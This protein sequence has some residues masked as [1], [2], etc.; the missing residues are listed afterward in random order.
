MSACSGATEAPPKKTPLSVAYRIASSALAA[1]SKVTDSIGPEV[2]RALP[3]VLS[4]APRVRPKESNRCKK[5]GI[6]KVA[7]YCQN[8][9]GAQV[10]F[11][12]IIIEHHICFDNYKRRAPSQ[13]DFNR[14]LRP[15]SGPSSWEI[16]CPL[17]RIFCKSVTAE[18]VDRP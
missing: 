1:K 13:C 15:H 12:R 3:P 4:R 2:Y 5:Q 10:F 11:V 17:W 9:F 6:S 7:S 14:P 8:A 16:Q 18:T